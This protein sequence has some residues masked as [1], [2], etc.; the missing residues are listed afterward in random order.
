MTNKID[1]HIWLSQFSYQIKRKVLLEFMMLTSPI[2]VLFSYVILHVFNFSII[3]IVGLLGIYCVFVLLLTRTHFYRE[4]NERNILE[5]LNR[6]FPQFEESAQLLIVDKTKSSLLTKLQQQKVEALFSQLLKDKEYKQKALGH[7]SYKS[8]FIV[9]LVILTSFFILKPFTQFH[10]WVDTSDFTTANIDH[11]DNVTPVTLMSQKIMITPPQYTNLTNVDTDTMDINAIS[12]SQ[13]TWKLG[14]SQPELTYSLVFSNGDEIDLIRENNTFTASKNIAYTGLYQIRAGDEFLSQIY[15]IEVINDQRP[16]IRILTPKLTITELLTN[17]QP[18]IETQ[19]QVSDDFGLSKVDILASI[20]KGSGESVK[21][22]DQVFEFDRVKKI[23]SVTQQKAALINLNEYHKSWN[24]ADLGMEP[25]DELYFT[26]RA[27]DNQSPEAQQTK[28]IT[29]IIRW[30]E[31]SEQAAMADGVLINFMPEYFKSQRQIIIETK[32]LIADSELL[33]KAEFSETSELLG[34]AQSELKQKYGQYLGD[35]FEGFPNANASEEP[36]HEEEHSEGDDHD[37]HEAGSGEDSHESEH[38]HEHAHQAETNNTNE[39]VQSAYDAVIAEYAHTH[40]DSDIG[41]MG[42]QDPVALMKRSVAN[43]WEAELYLM[44]SKPEQALPYE[45]QAL[46]F[47]K[48]AKKA[49]RIYVKRLGFEPP[50][51]SEQRRYQGE[52]DEISSLSQSQFIHIS[53]SDYQKLSRAFIFLNQNSLGNH[54]SIESELTTNQRS[55]LIDVKELLEQQIEGRP[56]LI[57]FIATIERILL[58]NHLILENCEGCVVNLRNKIWQIMPIPKAISSP[59]MSHGD[60]RE[61][62]TLEYINQIKLN[63]EQA[64]KVKNIQG[65]ETKEK[66]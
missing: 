60:P 45:E 26:V 40:E 57:E 41:L 54:V 61:T 38:N 20:A 18:I 7:Y 64:I 13:V 53:T 65:D 43:M 36:A 59:S 3:S 12:G 6:Q 25:G 35:E 22:R 52:L 49:E 11:E 5:H 4:V 23:P 9:A 39:G 17:A 8:Y 33:T 55:L 29:K 10:H 19:V 16:V 50:P 1:I 63:A 51:V 48:M 24:L 46:K 56:A 62:L 30:L 15:T 37:T 32:Q 42:K 34:I 27:W 14:F 66:K 44:L 58:A 28:S 21:F 31:D 47:L 2:W